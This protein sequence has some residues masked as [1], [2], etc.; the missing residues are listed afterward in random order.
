MLTPDGRVITGG[1]S[2]TR[3]FNSYQR[4]LGLL[5]EES[6]PG[7][8]AAGIPSDAVAVPADYLLNTCTQDN[9]PSKGVFIRIA[10]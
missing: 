5:A 6:G 3:G 4:Y 1:G 8:H 7:R 10:R 2:V 9:V